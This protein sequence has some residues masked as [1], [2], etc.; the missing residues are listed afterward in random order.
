VLIE[1]LA[2]LKERLD[3]LFLDGQ[4]IA[5]PRGFGLAS[6][7]GL[8]LGLPSIGCAKTRLVGEHRPVE[9]RRGSFSRLCFEGR[10]VGAAVRTRTDVKPIYVSP[11]D[12]ISIRS[13]VRLALAAC[14]GYRI[15]EPI[16]RAHQL[17]NRLRSEHGG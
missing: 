7:V 2:S 10:M 11:G 5:H 9:R 4:G 8:W 14:K 6:H 15:P 1:V 13:A 3:L 17:A 16:R 12:Q